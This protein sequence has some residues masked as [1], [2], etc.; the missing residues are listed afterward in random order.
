M[1]EH[2]KTQVYSPSPRRRGLVLPKGISKKS[3]M[4]RVLRSFLCPCNHMLCISKVHGWHARGQKVWKSKKPLLLKVLYDMHHITNTTYCTVGAK[5]DSSK[6]EI[7][8]STGLQ[9]EES[10]E[11]PETREECMTLR[12]IT[13]DNRYIV[14]VVRALSMRVGCASKSA[15]TGGRSRATGPRA[16]HQVTILYAII[17]RRYI[18]HE[19]NYSVQGM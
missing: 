15:R 16:K 3:N 18:L 11:G 4:V 2:L 17:M 1:R 13:Q 6:S 9:Q 14:A 10:T 7:S 8:I 5:M 12:H 19:K